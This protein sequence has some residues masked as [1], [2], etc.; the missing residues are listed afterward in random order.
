MKTLYASIFTAAA[1]WFLMFSPWTAPAIPFWPAMTASTLL[2]SALATIFCR[3]WLRDARPTWRGFFLGLGVAALL[4]CVFWV[5][6]KAARF[7]FDF[8]RPQVDMIYAMKGGVSP[9]IIAVLLLFIIGPAEEIFWRAYVQRNLAQRWGANRGFLAATAIYALV[10]IWSGNP[11]LVLA[12]L[13]IGALW[14]LFYRLWPGQLFALIVSHAVWDT[15]AFVV[16]P[17]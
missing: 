12:A 2:L 17:F 6:D 4:W 5:G 15:L 3:Q 10:H 16:A 7:L 14:G 13:V 1:L 8:A 11:M 9:A